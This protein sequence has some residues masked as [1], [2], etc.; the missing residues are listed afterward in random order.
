MKKPQSE[1][2]ASYDS[3]AENFVEEF[4]GELERKPFDRELLDA[5]AES[6]RGGGRVCDI[7]CGPGQIARRLR[8]RGVEMRGIDLSRE[9]VKFARRLNPDIPFEQ[10]DMLSLDVPDAS[11]AGI[12]CFYAIIHLGRKDAPRALA[13]MHRALRP[14]GRLLVSFHGGGGEL[15]RD[16]WYDKP[17]SIGV[18]LFE[19]EEMSGYMEAAGF[20]VERVVEREPYEFEYPTRRVYAFGRKPARAK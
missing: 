9:M 1:I 19:K 15:H 6:V 14:G 2:E 11:L 7:G 8:D 3:V 17:V 10:G 20:E 16:R 13:E 5:F 18:T 4:F 12:V